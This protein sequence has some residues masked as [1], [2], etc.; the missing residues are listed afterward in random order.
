[1]KKAIKNTKSAGIRIQGFFIIGNA[2][3][4]IEDIK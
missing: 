1:M 3:E 2:S 4:T